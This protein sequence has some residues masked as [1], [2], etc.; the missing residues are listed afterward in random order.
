MIFRL[1][2]R[3][4]RSRRATAGLTVLSIALAVALLL[5]VERIRTQARDAFASTVSGT[6][7]VVGARTSPVHL[8]LFAVFHVGNPNNNVRWD[9]YRALAARPDVAWT[10]PLAL[11]DSHRGFRVV[12]TTGDFFE[13]YRYARE[14][15]LVLAH[16][17]RFATPREAVL[18]ADVAQALHYTIGQEIVLAHGTGDI[19]SARH[20]EFPFRVAGILARTGTPLDRAVH[21]PLEGLDLVHARDA[22]AAAG[23][24]L[25]GAL[26]ARAARLA[27]DDSPHERPLSAVL[28]GLKS[29]AA[30]LSVQRA[31]NEYTGEPL[32]ALLPGVTLLEVWEVVGVAERAL[33][34]ISLLVLGVGL[35]GL[36]V[37]LLTTLGERR[38]EMAV[39]RSVGARPAQVF[40]LVLG[41]AMLLAA[42]GV[43]LGVAALEIL[44]HAGAGWWQA[45]LGF[46]FEPGRPALA[47]GLVMLGVI[48]AAALAGAWPAWRSYRYALVDG[49]TLRV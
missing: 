45:Q 12:G 36:L 2:L 48:L 22:A 6:D 43:V 30:A 1:A 41:E 17:A 15:G 11:G 28:V 38:R 3:S 34:A 4:L 27:H 8:L 46:A 21:V 31:L 25:A 37:A 42:G 33:R 19:E 5:G 7:L 20:A 32:T 10:I 18:G 40:G 14:R 26:A 29:R 49:M 9:T 44:L 47:D 24:P 35:A 16:G 39:L 13:H 23:D